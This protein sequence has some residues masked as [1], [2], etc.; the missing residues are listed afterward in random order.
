AG[1]LAAGA[2][3]G[4]VMVG[5][6]DPVEQLDASSWVEERGVEAREAAARAL[7]VYPPVEQ[8][9]RATA[10][11]VV[12]TLEGREGDDR[13]AALAAA[14]ELREQFATTLGR[15]GDE[16]WDK[17]GGR[18]FAASYYE[19]AL[20][21]DPD[22]ERARE[23][24]QVSSAELEALAVRAAALAFSE[25]ELLG[26]EPLVVLAASDPKS[27]EEQLVAL[28]DKRRR[29]AERLE[30][31]LV[32]L[33]GLDPG[34]LDVETA[35]PSK[36]PAAAPSGPVREPARE[37]AS[38]ESGE[39]GEAGEEDAV[40]DEPDEA[41]ARDRDADREQAATLAKQGKVALAGGKLESA[42][43]RFEQALG[44]DRRNV[45]ALAGLRDVA[46]ERGEYSSSVSFGERVIRIRANDAG[47]R[48]ALGDAYLKVLRYRDALA[49]YERAQALGESRA[50]WRVAKLRKQLG[51]G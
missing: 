29:R 32:A 30:Q 20:L 25:P 44:R 28:R 17:E 33:G 41:P 14:T 8:P 5:D 26:S 31:Q 42:A 36:E 48:L 45:A 16:Y 9:R 43:E 22:D 35:S 40:V 3:V 15:L 50:D 23:R 18:P 19:Q 4:G 47:H 21:F 49:Q 27:R 34:E 38:G 12:Q 46:F 7:F 6:A 37:S 1:L 2:V 10:Y 39:P 13:Q 11:S 51:P 24:S